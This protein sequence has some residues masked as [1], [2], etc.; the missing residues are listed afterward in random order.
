MTANWND[1]PPIAHLFGDAA[2]A[3]YTTDAD[4]WLTY[5]NTAAAELWGYRPEIGRTR[6]CGSW[7]IFTPQ[8]TELPLDQCPMAI[9]LK[10]VRPVRGVRAVLERPD[11]TLIP[12]MPYPTPIRASSGALTA[13]WN[14][15]VALDSQQ[16]RQAVDLSGADVLMDCAQ[17][18]PD[19]EDLDDLTGQLQSTLA[20]IA[21]VE[22]AHQIDCERLGDWSG[23]NAEKARI[24]AQLELKR[25]RRRAALM[26]KFSELQERT[27]SLS[28]RSSYE[29][30][31]VH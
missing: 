21:D 15:L 9:A 26:R 20:A 13:G 31:S 30:F 27:A 23:S 5:Y 2:T 8:G 16:A 24:V 11:G 4:G 12:F 3:I 6:W 19:G 7:R 22:V 28:L 10:E 18:L 1:E 29:R 17:K 14:M 25:E